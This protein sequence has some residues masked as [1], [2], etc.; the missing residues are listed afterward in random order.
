MNTLLPRG[1]YK[2]TCVLYAEGPYA[3]LLAVDI[4]SREKTEYL[5]N[6]YEGAY[7]KPYIRSYNAL[8]NCDSFRELFVWKESLVVVFQFRQG[9]PIDQVFYKGAQVDWHFRMKA[10]ADLFRQLLLLADTPPEIGCA[11]LLSDNIQVFPLED[12]VSVNY[13]IRPLGEMNQRELVFLLSDQIQKVLELRWGSPLVERDFV[14]ELSSGTLK[15]VVG[16]YG[17]W[18]QAEPVIRAAYEG[19]EKRTFVGR[20][21]HLALLNLKDWFHTRFPKRR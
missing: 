19:L 14:R 8:R 15:T 21:L 11:V 1:Q 6:V 3:A 16:A 20:M 10:A 13:M 9:T 2:V 5:L 7:V 18:A 12:C 17:R 4:L